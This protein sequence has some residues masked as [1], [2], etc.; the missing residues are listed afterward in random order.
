[1][2]PGWLSRQWVIGMGRAP[3]VRS[4]LLQFSAFGSSAPVIPVGTPGYIPPRAQLDLWVEMWLPAAYRGGDNVIPLQG[5]TRYFGTHHNKGALNCSD[6]QRDDDSGF[7]FRSATLRQANG[8][9]NYW[10]NQV[11]TSDQGIDFNGNSPHHDDPDQGLAMQY[12]DPYA[13]SGGT[14][15]GTG[16][17]P[18][19]CLISTPH[20]PPAARSV[21]RRVGSR[22][23]PLCPKPFWFAPYTAHA[24]R[25][26][27]IHVE[28]LG[29]NRGEWPD[30]SPMVFG[31]EC[32]P[33]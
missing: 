32:G 29:W 24:D 27:W 19:R 6:L 11:L 9:K 28:D 15:K 14:Y 4:I 26:R 21:T 7:P 20:V 2:F 3:K 5:A 16:G 25:R 22:R 13:L 10:A 12:H 33:A 23:V 1:M 30:F 31:P 8:T 17:V 18:E